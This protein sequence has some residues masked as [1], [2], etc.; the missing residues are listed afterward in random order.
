MNNESVS[1][2]Y[3]S[4]LPTETHI[5]KLPNTISEI[6]YFSDVEEKEE[7]SSQ[8]IHYISLPKIFELV[9]THEYQSSDI[10][11]A[12]LY[13]SCFFVS[14]IEIFEKLIERFRV[15]API[16]LSKNE[17]LFFT[18]KVLKVI[19][20]KVLI[21][22]QQWFK[23]NKA[24]LVF[25]DQTIEASF[26]EALYCL[27]RS[28][29]VG[30]WIEE[31]ISHFFDEIESLA[32][33]R[34]AEDKLFNRR[35]SVTSTLNCYVNRAYYLIRHWKK[36]ITH[37]LCIYD[38]RNFERIG[39]RELAHRSK[40]NL[41]TKNYYHFID[42]FNYLS[43][44]TSFL[45]L[46]LQ[47]S[48]TRIAFFEDLIDIVED[49]LRLNNF[50]SSYSIFLGLTYSSVSRLRPVLEQKLSKNYRNKM[51]KLANIFDKPSVFRETQ[52][53]C[54]LPCV[55]ALSFFTKDLSSI[56]EFFKHHEQTNEKVI[57]GK[58]MINFLKM[59]KIANVVKKIEFYKTCKYNFGKKYNEDFIKDLNYIPNIDEDILYDLSKKIF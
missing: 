25:A 5:I 6:I 29:D 21:F 36:E 3:F 55:P 54:L 15:V 27:V 40:R 20:I 43:K 16:N 32:K 19:Q 47:H 26:V 44:L 2:L 35:M 57:S 12:L 23:I 48:F 52:S 58:K 33:L 59:Q 9:T 41:T 38:Q 8:Q 56:D 11:N 24:S 28:K 7:N 1:L 4:F 17:H 34:S 10:F 39:S 46:Y 45:I 42:S 53:K 13:G 18:K 14:E 31:P 49:L 37:C 22:L 50:H 51:E 30:K